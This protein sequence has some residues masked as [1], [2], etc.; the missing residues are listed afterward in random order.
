[1]STDPPGWEGPPLWRKH[2]PTQAGET[3]KTGLDELM[4]CQSGGGLP[5]FDS[6]KEDYPGTRH[7][8]GFSDWFARKLSEGSQDLVLRMNKVLA[9]SFT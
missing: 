8:A 7:S 1:M 4:G 2:P 3:V 6:L 9:L 5:L